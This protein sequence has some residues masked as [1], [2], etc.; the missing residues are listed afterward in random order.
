MKCTFSTRDTN[1]LIEAQPGDLFV[2]LG[3]DLVECVCAVQSIE[4]PSAG[5]R[6][7]VPQRVELDPDALRPVIVVGCRVAPGEPE[8]YP[9]G[10]HVVMPGGTPIAFVE[11][12]E[13]AAFRERE[14]SSGANHFRI[15]VT[16]GPVSVPKPSAPFVA[17][18]DSNGVPISRL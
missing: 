1:I 17:C 13:P 16:R 9:A 14:S 6:T 18:V 2:P 8:F 7:D 11:Q 12:V 10:A 4:T 5:F 15:N 3:P